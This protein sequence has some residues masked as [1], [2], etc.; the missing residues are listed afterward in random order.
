[1]RVPQKKDD[2]EL[3]G[4]QKWTQEIINNY[5]DF[6][7]A[8]IF[9]KL[10]SLSGRSILWLSPLAQDEFA[11]Y[12]DAAFLQRIGLPELTGELLKFWPQNGP[13]WDALGKTSDE[14]AFIL[15]E[16]KAHVT[17]LIAPCGATDKESLDTISE[18][19]DKTQRWLNCQKSL[20]DWKSDY[21]Q[22][23]NRLAHLYFLREKSRK[24]AYLVFLYFLDDPTHIPTSRK[25]WDAALERKKKLMGL[26]AD[27]LTGKVIDLFID[28]RDI[29]AV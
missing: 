8:R 9:E 10:P 21:Y 17:E 3:K 19:L 18:S 28:T 15:V 12:Q 16:A 6:L 23:A 27:C 1:M 24:E 14:K 11:E 4:S 2:A 7:N 13:R 20:T 22:Y 5:P 29:T 25:D 26:S